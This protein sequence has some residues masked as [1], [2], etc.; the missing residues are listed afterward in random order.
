MQPTV[1]PPALRTSPLL[2]PGDFL[3][4]KEVSE[5]LR[6]APRTLSNWRSKR[7]GPVFLKVGKR[8]VRYRA[9][10]VEAFSATAPMTT[11]AD[12]A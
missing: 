7:E 12:F 11:L 4:E 9:S 3:T 5:R 6:V 8:M 1:R 10:D 2:K